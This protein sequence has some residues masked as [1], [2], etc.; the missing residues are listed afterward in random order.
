[1]IRV[2]IRRKGRANYYLYYRDPATGREISKS[3][4]TSD[5]GDAERAAQRWESELLET[6]GVDGCGWDYFCERF[7]DEHLPDKPRRTQNSY[8][9]ALAHFQRIIKVGSVAEV[10]SDHV[11][12]VRGA[13]LN[14]GRPNATVANILTHC[15]AAFKWAERIGMLRKAPVF[16]MPKQVKRR[17]MRGRPV[18]D[19]EL[20]L[21]LDHAHHWS[22]KDKS[23]TKEVSLAVAPT[24]RRMME[25]LRLSGLR[26]EEGSILSWDKPPIRVFLDVEPHPFLLFFGEGQK[27]G[28][29]EALPITPAFAAWLAQTPPE[30][31]RGLVAPVLGERLE[32]VKWLEI[33]RGISAIGKAA[34]VL[35]NEL[36]KYASAHDLRR[37]FGTE[38][39]LKVR[40]ITLQRMMRHKHISTTLKFYV[41]L[42]SADVGAE[43]W[44]EVSREKSRK[45]S[46]CG[47]RRPKKQ[48]K[49]RD[50]HK[51]K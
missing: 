32:P 16:S 10:T 39:A 13:L 29:D 18:T 1:M 51:F 34:G 19:A 5:K 48:A 28:E 12:R 46:Q 43:L 38:W 20:Q 22:D 7:E 35:V 24:W 44:K 2:Y 11:S 9:A 14:E 27:S 25:M 47:N 37:A 15:R 33:S 31:R 49:N 17:F 23:I 42:D 6:R 30:D 21:M 4:R 26:L 41:G 40:P 8:V 45:G 50:S 36:G 3:A